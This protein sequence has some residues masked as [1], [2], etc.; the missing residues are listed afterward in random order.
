L[1]APLTP[2]EAKVASFEIFMSLLEENNAGGVTNAGIAFPRGKDALLW[3]K[4]FV[5]LV[6]DRGLKRRYEEETTWDMINF[7]LD[8]TWYG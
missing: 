3:R 4:D 2:S 8:A 7:A 1:V 5:G 6:M